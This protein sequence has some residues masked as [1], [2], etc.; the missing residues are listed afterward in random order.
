MHIF[1]TFKYM[2]LIPY[3]INSK[4]RQKLKQP[5]RQFFGTLDNQVRLDI[6][7]ML[8]SS[9]KN[10]S[11]IAKKTNY[12]QTTISHNLRRLKECGFVN[13][14]QKGKERTYSINDNTIKPLFK[15]MQKHMYLYC[16]HVVAKKTR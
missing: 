10:V 9:P 3:V 13:V 14:S 15:L 4:M 2:L 11:Q 6:I 12:H 7:E 8:V 5:Y 16:R 1:E